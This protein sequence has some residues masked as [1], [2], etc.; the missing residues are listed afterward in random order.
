MGYRVV[1]FS[2]LYFVSL[3]GRELSS[4]WAKSSWVSYIKLT[5]LLRSINFHF[6]YWCS[7]G[8]VHFTHRKL[9]WFSISKVREIFHM[10]KSNFFFG[11]LVLFQWHNL[12][13]LSFSCFNNFSALIFWIVEFYSNF[14]V[15]K[16][17]CD[18]FVLRS[19][20]RFCLVLYCLFLKS[21]ISYQKRLNQIIV[22]NLYI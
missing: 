3:N 4:C 7:S 13:F 12:F 14:V 2:Y 9:R 8:T 5:S 17:F 20:F 6:H 18:V 1:L 11:I 10:L 21:F 19:D 22:I 15:S 16:R